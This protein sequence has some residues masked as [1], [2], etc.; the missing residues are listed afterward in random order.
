MAEYSERGAQ[1]GAD[2]VWSAVAAIGL[3]DTSLSAYT[4]NCTIT[5]RELVQTVRQG[6]RHGDRGRRA[7][8][9]RTNVREIGGH[10][11]AVETR[12]GEQR[13]RSIVDRNTQADDT[14]EIRSAPAAHR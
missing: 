4:L 9:R 13:Q 1:L 11:H 14:S 2:I 8:T 10:D 12:S 5:V 3:A 6:V 7:T